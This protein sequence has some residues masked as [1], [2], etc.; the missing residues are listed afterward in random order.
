LQ[1]DECGDPYFLNDLRGSARPNLC[2]AIERNVEFFFLV[3]GMIT[4]AVTGQFSSALVRAALSEPIALTSAVLVFGFVFRLLQ[5]HL[6]R[7]FS[8]AIGVFGQRWLC[9]GLNDHRGPFCFHHHRCGS[10]TG[11]RGGDLSA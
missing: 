8:Q 2:K 6:D 7:V 11:S 10:G 1:E 5:E 9:F 4:S 3:A